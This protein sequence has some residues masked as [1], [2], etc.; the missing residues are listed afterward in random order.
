LT[1]GS[2]ERRIVAGHPKRRRYRMSK[3]EERVEATIAAAHEV[4]DKPASERGVEDYEAIQSAAVGDP[5]VYDEVMR[6]L[7][8]ARSWIGDEAFY[9]A[10][11]AVEL[12]AANEE[13]LAIHGGEDVLSFKR[14]TP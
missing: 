1:A 10:S 8:A 11:D 4:T 13:L 9:S 6:R 7:V 3:F 5:D 2:G 14:R 12:A